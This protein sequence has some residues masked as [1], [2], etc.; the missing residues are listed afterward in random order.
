MDI[1]EVLAAEQHHAGT[2]IVVVLIGLPGSGKSPVARSLGVPIV[3]RGCLRNV[4]GVTSVTE[5]NL[6]YLE[7]VMVHGLLGAG[8]PV[9]V[10]DDHHTRNHYR[11][12]WVSIAGAWHTV[13]LH[14]DTPISE[15]KARRGRYPD[16]IPVIDKLVAAGE[17]VDAKEFAGLDRGSCSYYGSTDGGVSFAFKGRKVPR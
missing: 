7:Q 2:P 13:F 5:T 15:C 9:V 17:P 4:V 8:H 6:D 3:S 1:K 11:R 12:K 10:V 14:M 16:V